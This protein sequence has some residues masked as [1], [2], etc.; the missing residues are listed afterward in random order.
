MVYSSGRTLSRGWWRYSLG[1]RAGNNVHDDAQGCVCPSPGDRSPARA[2]G[3]EAGKWYVYSDGLWEAGNP[4]TDRTELCPRRASV[5]SCQ[6]YYPHISRIM[7]GE[8]PDTFDKGAGTLG[9]GASRDVGRSIGK[10]AC[11]FTSIF[12]QRHP[13]VSDGWSEQTVRAPPERWREARESRKD[14]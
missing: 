3:C 9:L 13:R 7:L 11:P 10:L 6:W 4:G 1:C 8:I 12:R 5:S 2:R 14:E